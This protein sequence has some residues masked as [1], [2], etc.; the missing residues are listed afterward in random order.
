ML[1]VP[2]AVAEGT[3]MGGSRTQLVTP[4]LV[5]GSPGADSPVWG[6]SRFSLFGEAWGRCELLLGN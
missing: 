3:E 6:H 4:P 1:S 2:R 5:A